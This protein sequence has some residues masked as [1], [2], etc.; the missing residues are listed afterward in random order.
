MV[1]G[2]LGGLALRFATIFCPA[3]MAWSP[4]IG[5]VGEADEGGEREIGEELLD[6]ALALSLS[7]S[8]YSAMSFLTG[9]VAACEVLLSSWLRGLEVCLWSSAVALSW[10]SAVGLWCPLL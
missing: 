9:T 10:S 5:E 4:A 7:P 6:S 1:A 8:S 3:L 2:G